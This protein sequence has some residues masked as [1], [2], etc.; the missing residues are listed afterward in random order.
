MSRRT[1]WLLAVT[2]VLLAALGA[3]LYWLSRPGQVPALLLDRIGAALGL[4]IS[5]SGG[6]EYQLRGTP[7]LLLRDVVAR[8]PGQARPLLRAGRVYLSLPWSS[9]RARGADLTIK[10][11]EFDDAQ[12][13]WPALQR[14]LASRPPSMETRIPTLTDG[15]RIRGGSIVNGGGG[16]R[17]DGISADLASLHPD[18]PLRTR[19]GGRYSA[20]PLS[21]GFDLALALNTPATLVA[22]QVSGF[23]ANGR[24]A[25]DQGDWRLPGH[26]AL[27]G[28]L[29][30]AQQVLRASPARLGLSARYESGA[31]SLPFALGLHGPLRFERSTWTLAPVGVALRGE[32]TIPVLDARGA[33][34]LGRRLAV[35]LDGTIA[36]WPDAWPTLPPPIGQS[37]SPLPFSLR[38]LGAAKLSD[39]A[40]LH[41][42]RDATTFDARFRLPT[43]LAWLDSEATS[44]LP[45]LDGRLL[46]PRL[47]ISGAVLE[48]VEVDFDD[49]DVDDGDIRAP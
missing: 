26:V 41:L 36:Q 47:E 8:E 27:S 14:W 19:V 16:W 10:R 25:I 18:R 49:G 31:T 6:A 2:L 40:A 39:I 46:T 42:R 7:M 38:Y 30:W 11:V 5:A 15:L 29:Q 34:A 4:E 48:G 20:P 12:L 37:R 3:S 1:R 24:I 43:M 9:I 17:I 33:L 45:P 32:G 35:H 22:G 44:P 13:D 21:I 23:G 28:P